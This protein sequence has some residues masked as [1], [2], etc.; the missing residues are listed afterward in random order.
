MRIYWG[1]IMPS[2]IVRRALAALPLLALAVPL[3]AQEAPVQ[4]TEASQVATGWG[5]RIYDIPAD[6]S[7]RFGTLENGMRYAIMANGT[8]E[9]T[10]VVRFGFDVGWID[11]SEE[12]LGLAHVVEHMAFNGSTNVP[13]GEMIKLLERLGLAFGADTNASTG[14]EDTIYK[15]DLPRT[16]PELIDTALMLMRETAS[17]LTI[18]DGAVDRER[19]IIQSETRTRNNYQIRRIKDYFQFVAP[20]TRYATRFRA[21]GT[22]ENID[23]ATGATVRGLYDRYYRPDNAA[24]VVVGDIDPDVI[25]AKIRERFSDWAPP[26]AAIVET[27]KGLIDLERGPTAANFVDP[28][29]QYIVVIDRFAPYTERLPTVDEFQQSL[30]VNL[31]SAILN[32]RLEKIANQADAPI[33]AASASASDFFD[34]HRQ[35]SLTLQAKEGEWDE[36]LAVGEQEWRRAAEYGFTQAELAEQLA[37]F[38]TSYRDA[39]LQQDTRRNSQLAEGILATAKREAIFVQPETNYEMFRNF[40]PSIT[41]Q[42]VG[43]AFAAHYALSDPL[44]HVSTKEP[45]AQPEETILAAYRQSEQVA[46]APPED[47]GQ[48]SFAYDSFG[49]PGTIVSDTVIE[50]LGIRTIRFDNNVRL[51]LKQTDFEQGRLRYAVRIGSGQLAIPAEG[52]A[53]AVFLSATSA[54]GGVGEHSYD[55]LQQI[56]AGRR[57]TYGLNAGDDQFAIRGAGTM[58]DLPTQMKLSAA[59]VADLGLRPEMLTKWLALVPPFLAQADSTPQAVAQFK[60]GEIV[61]DANPRF[62][63]PDQARLESVTLD[64]TRAL[65]ADQLA[66]APIE[67]SVV[68]DFDNEEVIASVASTFGALPD[69]S[70]SLQPFES[71]RVANFASDRTPRTLTHAGAEDQ[72]LAL[73]FWPTSDDDDA[74]EEATMQLLATAM[75][76]EMLERIREELGAS[77]SP[78]ADSSMSDTYRDYGTFSTSVIVEPGQA[79]EV[80][81]VVDAIAREFRDAPVDADL[82]DRAR[83]PLL[84]SIALNRRENGWWLGVMDEAQ[85]RSDR[86]DRTRSYEE[87]VRAVTPEMLQEAARRYLDPEA[88]L[89][90]RIVHESLAE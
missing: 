26:A 43:Q 54:L 59:Y 14:F 46:V 36:A 88:A 6:A 51:N 73:T 80:F 71:E 34:I 3:A 22:V 90:I 7:V 10:A 78:G 65:V 5:K 38:E 85:L 64:G 17:E 79:D 27:N 55:E 74:Q 47:G 53:E 23:V 49:T 66:N 57:L 12:E 8:P 39:A 50:D 9:D 58:A 82:L 67:I 83:K 81:E 11:E 75:R 1:L 32:R 56:L 42:A 87:R 19:G 37:N 18:A 77:Y 24:L 44:I 33:I 68:G 70:A 29:V 41:P 72:A 86:L 2:N 13:E 4:T 60:V 48:V 31:G 63:L 84:E 15:L 69:R 21:D 52:M 62:A 45:I 35:A 30:L 20:D 28:D 40:A 61:A 89:R 76:L 16:D 25:E